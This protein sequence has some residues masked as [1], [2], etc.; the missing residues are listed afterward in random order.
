[1]RYRKFSLVL[2]LVVI[3]SLFAGVAHAQEG[4]AIVEMF[5]LFKPYVLFK[6]TFPEEISGNFAGTL[7]GKHFDCLQ[8]APTVLICIGPFR[9]PDPSFLTIYD[10]DTEE[11]IL[12]KVVSPP[13]FP[14]KEFDEP[15]PPAPTPPPSD[16][17]DAGPG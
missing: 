5:S 13:K 3:L 4:S 7:A 17:D 6:I 15:E 10:Q 8:T 14:G 1:M 9:D 2:I 16:D 12:Q 11:I